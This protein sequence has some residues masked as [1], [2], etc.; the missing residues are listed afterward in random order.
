MA[1]VG[2]SARAAA[3]VNNARG[4]NGRRLAPVESSPKE[5]EAQSQK[6]IS[7]SSKDT[8]PTQADF[9]EERQARRSQSV[10]A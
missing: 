6:K 5:D 2:M 7:L 10:L 1:S 8:E 9:Q 4:I 3:I